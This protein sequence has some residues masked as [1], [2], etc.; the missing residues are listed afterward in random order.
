MT[1]EKTISIDDRLA[2]VVSAIF[3][4][5]LIPLYGLL[6]IFTAPAL[7]GYLP[8]QVKKIV[9]FIIL[10][11]NVLLPVMLI[12]YFRFRN[13][14]TTWTMES[15]K[16][17]ILPLI[18]TSFFYL[19]SVYPTLRFNIPFFVKLFI[20][21]SAFLAIAV[22]IVNFWYKISIHATGAG[23]MTAL[24]MILSLRMHAPLTGLMIIVILISGLVMSSRLWLGSHTPGE[25]WSGFLLGI[26][27]LCLCLCF[28]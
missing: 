8:M 13:I 10:I 22:T 18:T 3:H 15:R 5:L 2:Q 7:Y 1:S 16:E 21:C 28:F 23:A 14:I 9:F 26:F 19:F 20:I 6:I 25:V 24:V 12:S 27:G 11:E 17:R 4:P